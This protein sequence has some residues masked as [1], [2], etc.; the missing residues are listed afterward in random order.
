MVLV[1]TGEKLI[2]SISMDVEMFAF[3]LSDELSGFRKFRSK[4]TSGKIDLKT[5]Y[6]E[7]E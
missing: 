1:L 6:V 3:Q 5:G 7:N 4:D 2:I